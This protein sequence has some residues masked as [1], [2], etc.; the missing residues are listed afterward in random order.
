M[1][2]TIDILNLLSRMQV[3]LYTVPLAEYI[4]DHTS[5]SL[6]QIHVCKQDKLQRNHLK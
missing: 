2:G 1:G 3:L 5:C 6:E 4:N